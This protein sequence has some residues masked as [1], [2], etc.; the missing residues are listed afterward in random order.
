V[1]LAQTIPSPHSSPSVSRSADSVLVSRRS[2][3]TLCPS[4]ELTGRPM[5]RMISLTLSDQPTAPRPSGRD[6]PSHTHHFILSRS[7][8]SGKPGFG[9]EK[10][11]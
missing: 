8:A 6:L 1:L 2:E 4:I 10:P 7:E 9:S 5:V 11:K 3:A